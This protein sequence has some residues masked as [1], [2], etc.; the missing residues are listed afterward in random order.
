MELY[1]GVYQI[2]SLLGERNLFQYLFA[3]ERLMLVDSGVSATPAT[4]IA[5]YIERTGHD[6]RQLAMVVTTHPDMDHQGGNSELRRIARSAVVA[7]GEADRKLVEDP[8]CLYANRYNYMRANHGLGFEEEPPPEAGSYCRVDTGFEAVSE[9]RSLTDGR[10]MSIT[11]R[12]T[13]TDILPYTIVRTTP[14]S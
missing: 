14:L 1:R 13:P 3:A 7:C 10:S 2:Q 8:R 9:S 11:F 6:P 12:G 5:P 4:T